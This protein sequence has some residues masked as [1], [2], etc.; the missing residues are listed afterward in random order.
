MSR[1]ENRT[2]NRLALALLGGALLFST[3]AFAQEVDKKTERAWKAKCSSCHGMDG[4]ATTRKGQELKVEDMS[5]AAYQKKYSDD[6]MR[7]TINDGLDTTRDGRK[8][9][10]DGYKDQLSE[11]QVTSLIQYIRGLGGK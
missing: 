11:E 8:V 2:S 3:S 6:A 1:T 10:M 9:E 4:K 5:T 7:K